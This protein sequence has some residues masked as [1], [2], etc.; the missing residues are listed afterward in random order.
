MEGFHKASHMHILH[1]CSYTVQLLIGKDI[2]ECTALRVRSDGENID[3]K[4][5][6]LPV[7]ISYVQLLRTMNY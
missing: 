5:L 1:Y 4:H 2:D 6:R 7:T 3:R